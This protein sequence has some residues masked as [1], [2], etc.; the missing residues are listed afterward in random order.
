MLSLLQE[1][2]IFFD[3]T[4]KLLK[5]LKQ[6]ATQIR[7][8]DVWSNRESLE[9]Y[10]P[11]T[12]KYAPRPDLPSDSLNE[13][14][15][16]ERSLVTFLHEQL[17]L[18]LTQ[19]IEEAI[20]THITKL[21]KS[22]KYATLAQQFIPGLQLYYGQNMSLKEIFP[23]LGMTSWNQARRILN[24]GDL[25]KKSEDSYSETSSRKNVS[26]SPGKRSNQNSASTGLFEQFN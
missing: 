2:G 10:N 7:Q 14:E 9:I 11:D 16:E 13:L 24:P 23:Q 18:A 17:N 26:Q 20:R 1:R 15:I 25:L 21:Q 12:G 6:V 4:N 19:G 22:K 5:A 8:Y 3:A